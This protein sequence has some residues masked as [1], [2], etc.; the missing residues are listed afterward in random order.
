M[1]ILILDSDYPIFLEWW[2][3]HNPDLATAPYETQHDRR[4][5]TYFGAPACFLPDAFEKAGHVVELVYPNNELMQLAWGREHGIDLG[6]GASVKTQIRRVTNLG[7]NAIRR[8]PVPTKQLVGDRNR[9]PGWYYEILE[10]QIATIAPDVILNMGLAVETEFLDRVSDDTTT[11]VGTVGLPSLMERSFD[12]YDLVVSHIPGGAAQLRANGVPAVLMRHCFGTAVLEHLEDGPDIPVS[13][14][15]SF[16]RKHDH[17]I[18]LLERLCRALPMHVWGPTVETLPKYSP[19]R[20]A[21]Q[22][23]AWGVE[24]Y[25]LVSQSRVTVNV[26]VDNVTVPANIRLYEATGVGTCLVTDSQERLAEIFD[27]DVEVVTYSSADECIET[28]ERLLDDDVARARIAKAGQ[29]RTLTEHTCEE[30]VRTLLDAIAEH[31]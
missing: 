31:T 9:K 16:T 21:Y 20:D 23:Q 15:G 5:D 24:M 17:R 27:P 22:G 13:F 12:I 25:Q 7:R 11:L 19:I 30:R 3:N 4:M 18:A 29:E 2:Y 6:L 10:E 28:I 1:R 14:I 26:H 8:L